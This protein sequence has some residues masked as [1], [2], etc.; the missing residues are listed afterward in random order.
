MIRNVTFYD[1]IRARG[2][3]KA[4]DTACFF[5][6]STLDITHCVFIYSFG[7][8]RSDFTFTC[9][10][11]TARFYVAAVVRLR[12]PL[13][14]WAWYLPQR[15]RELLGVGQRRGSHAHYLHAEGSRDHG[16]L[17]PFLQSLRSN[18]RGD[19]EGGLFVHAQ[20]SLGLRADVSVELGNWSACWRDG[21]DPAVLVPP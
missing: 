2:S 19:Q 20:R 10:F 13:A 5:L 17:H 11:P 3:N 12:A 15:G 8:A 16:N 4:H 1:A 18:R 14:R 21:E 9:C 7:M 6:A